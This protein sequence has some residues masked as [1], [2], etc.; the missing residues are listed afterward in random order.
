MQ[1]PCP[2]PEMVSKSILLLNELSILCNKL[3]N[4]ANLFDILKN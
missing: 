2:E 4:F 3:R 1:M